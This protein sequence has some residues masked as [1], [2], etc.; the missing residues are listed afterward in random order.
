M[1]LRCVLSVLG[2]KGVLVTSVVVLWCDDFAACGRLR[3]LSLVPIK[4][5]ERIDAFIPSCCLNTA[6]A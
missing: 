6:D 5:L 3:S 1:R 2:N 4:T